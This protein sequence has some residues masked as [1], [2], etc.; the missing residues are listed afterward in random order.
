MSKA[1]WSCGLRHHVVYWEVRVSNLC[2]GINSG[3]HALGYHRQKVE[4]SF[5]SIRKMIKWMVHAVNKIKNQN[6]HVVPSNG[7]VFNKNIFSFQL[8]ML[9]VIHS[10]RLSGKKDDKKGRKS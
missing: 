4:R 8:I 10:L 3:V 9:W 7:N 2:K 1:P 5:C 6:F